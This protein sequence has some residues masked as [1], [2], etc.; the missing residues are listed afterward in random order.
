METVFTLQPVGEHLSFT[1]HKNIVLV[2][3]LKLCLWELWPFVI[4]STQ[5]ILS[6][7]IGTKNTNYNCDVSYK[8]MMLYYYYLIFPYTLYE[9]FL[10]QLCNF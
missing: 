3:E 4:N 5:Q 1:L 9:D 6:N 7:A 2:K 8:V 10:N